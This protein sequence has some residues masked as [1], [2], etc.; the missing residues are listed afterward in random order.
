[1]KRLI[2]ILFT[3]LSLVL[4]HPVGAQDRVLLTEKPGTFTIRR[5][6]LSGL[7]PDYQYGRNCTF[8]KAEAAESLAELEKLVQVF[9]QCPV[10]GE[11]K[12][13]DATCDLGTGR[14]SSEYGYG[15]PSIMAFY[16]NTWSLYKGNEGQWKIEPPQWR[17]EINMTDKYRDN[18]FNETDFSNAYN[19]TNPAFSETEMRRATAEVNDLFYQPGVKEVIKPGIDRY[20]EIYVVHN[21]EQPPYWEQVT[22]REAYR[23]IHNYWSC[24]PDKAQSDIMVS[25]LDLEFSGFTEIEKEDFAYFG[26]P[27]SVYRIVSAKNGTPV[28]RANPD[29]WNRNLPRSAIQIMVLEVPDD[30]ALKSKKNNSLKA[31]DGYYYIYKLLEELDISSL[32]PL[33][34]HQAEGDE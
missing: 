2:N 20:G 8:T 16:L 11:I 4:F 18:G 15:V 14:C 3:L 21:P 33:I 10:L 6:N 34:P 17:M 7:G 27:E 31:G 26:N 25:A 32:L 13:F 22:I 12:G 24:V 30:E 5:G 19:P 28:L 29:Y 9:R 23:L 1:M